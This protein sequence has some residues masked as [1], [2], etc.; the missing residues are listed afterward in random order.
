LGYSIGW[1]ETGAEG[2]DLGMVEA[3]KIAGRGEGD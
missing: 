1:V 3:E 2:V